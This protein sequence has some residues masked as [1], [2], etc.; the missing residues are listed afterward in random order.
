MAPQALWLCRKVRSAERAPPA[1]RARA[2]GGVRARVG[3]GRGAGPAP[4][5]HC[6]PACLDLIHPHTHTPGWPAR[7]LVLPRA[8]LEAAEAWEDAVDAVMQ[9]F[10]LTH[11]R[12]VTYTICYY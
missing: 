12:R 4:C 7:P 1:A 3:G 8:Q 10:E 6:R 2:G 11:Q 5:P 9:E